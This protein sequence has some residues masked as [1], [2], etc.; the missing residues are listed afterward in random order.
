MALRNDI[1]AQ[2]MEEKRKVAAADRLK[3]EMDYIGIS[4]NNIIPGKK[5][6]CSEV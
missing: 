5:T 6:N 2:A 3:R 4:L 1:K